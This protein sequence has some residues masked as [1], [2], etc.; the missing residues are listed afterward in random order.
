M[1]LDLLTVPASSVDVEPAFSG[2]RLMM[3]RLQHQM[4]LRSFQ[5]QMAVGSWYGTPLLPELDSAANIIGLYI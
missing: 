3:N 1:A 2:G 4:S 5:A